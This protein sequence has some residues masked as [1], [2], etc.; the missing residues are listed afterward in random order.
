MVI[1]I[2]DI[3]CHQGSLVG[4]SLDYYRCCHLLPETEKPLAFCR[5]FFSGC[6]QK[7]PGFLSLTQFTYFYT[8]GL[9]KQKTRRGGKNRQKNKGHFNAES[10]VAIAVGAYKLFFPYHEQGKKYL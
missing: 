6:N 10:P 7:A 3:S 5:H 9:D 1:E 2:H 4:N 8:C